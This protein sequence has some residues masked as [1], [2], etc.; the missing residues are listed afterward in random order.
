MKEDKDDEYTQKKY[1]EAMKKAEKKK[2]EVL[3]N[4]RREKDKWVFDGSNSQLYAAMLGY[5]QIEK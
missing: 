4:Y 2:Q 3:V 5:L 1:R